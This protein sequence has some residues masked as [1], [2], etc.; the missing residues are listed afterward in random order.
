MSEELLSLARQRLLAQGHFNR[1]WIKFWLDLKP[2]DDASG[3]AILD[4]FR[5]KIEEYVF[6]YGRHENG[7]R[8]AAYEVFRL[9]RVGA[10]CYTFA[11]AMAFARW[12]ERLVTRIGRSIFRLYDYHGDSF[13]DLVDSLPLAGRAIVEQMLA[14]GR[15][16]NQPPRAGFLGENELTA[17]VTQLGE[18][19]RKLILTG[20][21]YVTRAL[22]T[23]AK[24]AYL[25]RVLCGE[26]GNYFQPYWTEHEQ[27]IAGLAWHE[28]D[29]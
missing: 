15:D 1:G 20:E 4:V 18:N 21:N 26:E 16:S 24:K 13:S 6:G 8:N 12:Y 29:V 28:E 5:G 22:A 19:W 7:I 11:E 27:E 14:T 17:A 25:S 10:S 3:Y 9:T 2:C 23:E